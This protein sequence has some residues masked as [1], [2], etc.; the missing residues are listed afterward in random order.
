MKQNLVLPAFRYSVLKSGSL[1]TG[2]RKSYLK[3]FHGPQSQLLDKY[4]EI[5]RKGH[6]EPFE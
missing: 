4:A 1:K 5:N 2:M 6:A 3:S